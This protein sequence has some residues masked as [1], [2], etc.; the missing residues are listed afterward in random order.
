M[1][2][3]ILES[4]C[5]VLF[6]SRPAAFS[7]LPTV[8]SLTPQATPCPQTERAGLRI[9]MC[10][11]IDG[12]LGGIPAAVRG[13]VVGFQDI[14]GTSVLRIPYA[15]FRLRSSMLRRFVREL[16]QLPLFVGAVI[17][18]QP[19]VVQLE[20]SFD[21]KTLVRDSLYLW[22]AHRLSRPVIVRSHGGSFDE[23]PRW[24][25]IWRWWSRRFLLS[26]DAV[27]VLARET[28]EDLR[29]VIEDRPTF[30]AL[31][32]PVD[33]T[34]IR[35]AGAAARNLHPGPDRKIAIV[36]AGRLIKSKGVD[37]LVNAMRFIQSNEA[38]LYVF[39]DGPLLPTLKSMVRDHQLEDKVHFGGTLPEEQLLEFY[40]NKADIFAFPSYP[41][42]GFPMAFFFAVGCGLPVVSTR[43]RP[44]PDYL[45]E[46]QNCLWVE[47]QDPRGIARQLDHLIAN[48]NLRRSQGERNR[49]LVSQFEPR[50]VAEQFA[51]LYE[52]VLARWQFAH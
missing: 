38:M 47:P 19:H 22:I 43:V 30:I 35:A 33:L 26:C 40:S 37:D 21:R 2:S 46:P 42:E 17:R 9:L 15:R 23:I 25:A 41:K 8:M 44:V 29:R 36:S 20:S 24:H 3:A 4:G 1:F 31:P 52:A 50:K 12:L 5:I 45:S 6:W 16:L 32:N 10:S 34:P 39:G 11:P 18:F 27:I 28:H 51:A 7:K 14:P 13:L 48:A 49:A